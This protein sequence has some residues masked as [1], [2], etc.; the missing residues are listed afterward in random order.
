LV[1]TGGIG[2][3]APLIRA[4]ICEGLGYLGIKVD[5]R[6]NFD[7]ERVISATASAVAVEAFQT[8][9]ELMIARHVQHVLWSYGST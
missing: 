1:F 6:R 9:E 5:P 7:G 3:N 4:K 8:N 2:A